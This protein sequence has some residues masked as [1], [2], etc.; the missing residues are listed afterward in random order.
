MSSKHSAQPICLICQSADL[1]KYLDLGESTLANAF[2]EKSK[3]GKK[4]P[5]F[6]LQVFLLPE[7]PSR[8]ARV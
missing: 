7:L 2:V 6:P 3:L 8:A 1:V 4:E 5:A